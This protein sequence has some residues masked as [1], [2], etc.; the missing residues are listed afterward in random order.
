MGLKRFSPRVLFL[1]SYPRAE[2]ERVHPE[3][4]YSDGSFAAA[5]EWLRDLRNP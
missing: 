5:R 2:R 3:P 4:R 1:G